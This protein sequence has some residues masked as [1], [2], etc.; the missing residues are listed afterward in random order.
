MKSKRAVVQKKC[1]FK[2]LRDHNEN[3]PF[4]FPFGNLRS[5]L[6]RLWDVCSS[7]KQCK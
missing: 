6:V 7:H 5:L 4:N 1:C 2:C 3:D